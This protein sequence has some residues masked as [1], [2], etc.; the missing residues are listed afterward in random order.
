MT[1]ELHDREE[2]T[3]LNFNTL[4]TLRHLAGKLIPIPAILQ[5]SIKTINSI[6]CMNN[7]LGSASE[8][9]NA[10]SKI[11]K[12]TYHLQ[13]FEHRLQSYLASCQGT[14]NTY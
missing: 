4:Q 2:Y 3:T 6:Q 11:A 12:T 5:A 9:A 8:D 7:M 13:S 14:P 10:T 1:S